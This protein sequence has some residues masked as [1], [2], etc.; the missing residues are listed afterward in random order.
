MEINSTTSIIAWRGLLPMADTGASAQKLYYLLQN[1][2]AKQIAPDTRVEML[3][4]LHPIMQYIT[5]W[6]RKHFTNCSSNLTATQLKIHKFNQSLYKEFINGYKLTNYE[7]SAK[8]LATA[9]SQSIWCQ[10][11]IIMVREQLYQFVD[12]T[13]WQELHNLYKLALAKKIVNPAITRNYLQAL[14]L[15]IIENPRWRQNEQMVICAALDNWVEFVKLSDYKTVNDLAGKYI[16]DLTQA[17]PPH[18]LTTEPNNITEPCQIFDVSGLVSHLQQLISAVSPEELTVG[19]AYSNNAEHHLPL[20]VITQLIELWNNTSNR[21][22][23]R[24]ATEKNVLLT[25]G[26]T[27]THNFLTAGKPFNSHP[28]L[29]EGITKTKDIPDIPENSVMMVEEEEKPSDTIPMLTDAPAESAEQNLGPD[30]KTSQDSPKKYLTIPGKIINHS[31]N[32]YSVLWQADKFPTIEPGEIIGINID[33]KWEVG[34]LRWLQY[35]SAE[36][37]HLG[38]EI[39][40]TDPVAIAAQVIVNKKPLGEYLRGLLLHDSILLPSVPFH[41]QKTVGIF[42]GDIKEHKEFK[43]GKLLFSSSCFQQFALPAEMAQHHE[44]PKV[45]IPTVTSLEQEN[46]Q[47]KTEETKEKS[48]PKEVLP[49]TDFDDIWN[50]L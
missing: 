30:P 44:S 10:H 34:I 23:P 24:T 50:S 47:E 45:S 31:T 41:P 40:T 7:L 4:L 6:L 20:P 36:Q 32:G 49:K 1:I 33:S 38:I 43:L 16:V 48:K 9:L 26:L 13:I 22:T 21:K 12:P 8:N 14:L 18:K 46:T 11:N 25:I 2:N 35:N 17:T 15:G 42:I 39:L 3:E 37:L 27:A 19:V 29:I 28:E 5:P